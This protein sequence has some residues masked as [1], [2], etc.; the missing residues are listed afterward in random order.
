MTFIETAIQ[1]AYV[2]EL[3]PIHDERGFFAVAFS[4]AEF[5]TR[6]L[7]PHV[8]QVN[9]SHNAARGTLRGLH[10]QD[11]PFA[12]AKVVRCLAGAAWDVMVD[13]RPTSPTFRR[14][15]GVE[16]SGANHRALYIPEG[17]AH[18]FQTLAD[19]TNMMYTVSAPYTSSHYRGVRWND[20]AFGIS[21]PLEPTV[22]H[23]RDRHY[24]DVD[25][26]PH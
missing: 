9:Y 17:V 6:G 4:R 22:M 10:Y 11:A 18:G 7:N 21:W 25:P 23:D 12:E 8:E 16:I 24:P 1:G 14:W 15:V 5:L 2:L 3:A 20:P 19:N 13:L 26:L